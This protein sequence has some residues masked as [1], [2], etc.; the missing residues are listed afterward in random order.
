MPDTDDDL[1][2]ELDPVQREQ[3]DDD[4]EA[5]R[6]RR[7]A[8]A[9]A[10]AD[11]FPTHDLDDEARKHLDEEDEQ[12]RLDAEDATARSEEIELAAKDE[13]ALEEHRLRDEVLDA[14]AETTRAMQLAYADEQARDVHRQYAANDKQRGIGDRAHGRHELD[15]AAARPDDLGSPGLAAEGRRFQNLA[16]IEERRSAAEDQIADNYDASAQEHRTEAREAQPHASGAVRNPPE[17]APEAQLPQDR[18]HVRGHG[19]VRDKQGKALKPNPSRAGT[20]DL[21]IDRRRER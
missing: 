1:S 20:P 2:V 11:K 15:E 12:A 8:K 19:Q 13:Q 5:A 9:R 6:E 10:Q 4:T 17:E 18:L 16:T 3:G 14:T 21:N 7:A